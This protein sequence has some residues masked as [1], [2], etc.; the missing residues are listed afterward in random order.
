MIGDSKFMYNQSL[1]IIININIYIDIYYWM[2]MKNT[3]ELTL[4]M[5]K[6]IP[7]E[8]LPHIS[9]NVIAKVR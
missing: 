4:K 3:F 8:V 5:G 2:I 9:D 7:V 1:H 6:K